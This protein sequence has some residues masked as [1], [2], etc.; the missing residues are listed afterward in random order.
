MRDSLGSASDLG[1]RV[2]IVIASA[3]RAEI[4]RETL[5]YLAGVR[6]ADALI[7]V[8]LPDDG[9]APGF[10]PDRTR[11]VTGARGL[12]AQRNRALDELPGSTEFV[13]FFD[14][15]ALPH[16]DYFSEC[17]SAFDGSPDVIGITGHVLRDGARVGPIPVREGVELLGEVGPVHR[18]AL[19]PVYSLYG[20]N[21][22]VRGAGLE[23]ERFDEALPLYSWLE[24][25]D[26]SRRLRRHGRIGRLSS[27]ACVHL[28]AQSGGRTDHFRYGYSQIANPVH[29]LRKRSI[30]PRRLWYLIGRPIASNVVG[31]AVGSGRRDRRERL[32]GNRKAMSDLL[33]RRLNPAAILSLPKG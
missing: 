14:D 10:V 17:V 26:F 9:S 20:C 3:G 22:V 32:Q 6:P 11:I 21:F 18:S 7:I 33:R 24:D 19:E 28:G 2:A 25:E 15:D 23:R 12:T 4:L 30:P 29:L 13:F 5:G 27:A 1:E 31:A 16:P 8:S